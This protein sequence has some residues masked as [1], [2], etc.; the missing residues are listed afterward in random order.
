M[1]IIR[2]L[3]ALISVFSNKYEYKF[4]D[5]LNF[6]DPVL[7][8]ELTTFRFKSHPL[9]FR[10]VHLTLTHESCEHVPIVMYEIIVVM[11]LSNII[12]RKTNYDSSAI[13]LLFTNTFTDCLLY[14]KD[15]NQ[16]KRG[17]ECFIFW[18]QYFAKRF[19]GR[20]R[21]IFV[22]S[23]QCDQIRKS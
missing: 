23:T 4:Y 14:Q 1:G 15:E 11:I 3:F 22:G 12:F 2:S 6:L 16:R 13:S 8:I 18:K 7:G 20:R 5:K 19:I 17:R 9:T 21:Q 10:P